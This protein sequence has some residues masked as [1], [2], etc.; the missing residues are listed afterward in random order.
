MVRISKRGVAACAVVLAAC[1]GVAGLARGDDRATTASILDVLGRDAAH[2]DAL[3][4]WVKRTQE[5]LER[6][7]RFRAA[8]DEAHAR[9][10]DGLA[11]ELA[12]TALDLS[13]T[14]DAE[15][16]ADEARRAATDA[17]VV[18]ERERAL[19]E[20]G[21]ARNGRLRAEIEETA[22]PRAEART[23]RTAGVDGGAR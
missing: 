3:A 4:P 21:I 8:G 11:R 20:E 12:E 15:N 1:V 17:G 7:S 6:A 5:A 14:I 10:A 2:K 13:K 16:A 22:R 18:G 19:L 23:S 9:I